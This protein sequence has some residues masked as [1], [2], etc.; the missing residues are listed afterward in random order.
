MTEGV[1][2][3]AKTCWSGCFTG[4]LI[5]LCRIWSRMIRWQRSISDRRKRGETPFREGERPTDTKKFTPSVGE[6][7]KFFYEK[8]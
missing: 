5:R 6:L 2:S 3:Q 8:S 4:I 1:H 7:E